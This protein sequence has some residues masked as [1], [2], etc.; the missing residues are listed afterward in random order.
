MAA[1]ELLHA[2]PAS[3]IPNPVRQSK[4]H[5]RSGSSPEDP[6]RKPDWLLIFMGVVF[7]LT[8]LIAWLVNIPNLLR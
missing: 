7:L 2:Q 4:G 1:Q 5:K 3:F 8:L 6:S